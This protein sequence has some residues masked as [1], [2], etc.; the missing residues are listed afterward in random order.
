MM[1]R[2]HPRPTRSIGRLLLSAVGA[3]VLAASALGGLTPTDVV[4][5]SRA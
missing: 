1:A 2:G 3:A 4:A 5:I